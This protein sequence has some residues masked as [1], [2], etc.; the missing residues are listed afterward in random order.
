MREATDVL[1]AEYLDVTGYPANFKVKVEDEP[2]PEPVPVEDLRATWG[3][4]PEAEATQK[5]WEKG[6]DGDPR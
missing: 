5:A 6:T 3:I 1:D 4:S 2:E